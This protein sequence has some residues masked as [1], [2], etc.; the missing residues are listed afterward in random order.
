M[1]FVSRTSAWSACTLEDGGLAVGRRVELADE[2]VAVQHGEREVAPAARRLG[3]VHLEHVLEVEELDRTDAVVDEPVERREERGA[4]LERP[5][6]RLGV[7]PPLPADALDDR[8]LARV[9]DVDGLHRHRPGRRARD[10]HR[11]QPA[12]VAS[13]QGLVGR[14]RLEVGRVDALGE[15]PEPL[16][17]APR[18]HRD[19]A[20][21]HEELEHLRHVPVAGPAARRPRHLARV[22]HVAGE[23]RPGV[24]QARQH[25]LAEAGIRVEPGAEGLAGGPRPQLGQ[26]ERQIAHRPDERVELEQRPVVL[27]G[28]REP[29]RV[30]RRAEPRPGDEV[31]A[32]GDRR[33]RVELEEREAL[34]HRHELGRP[35]G[36]EQL[37]ADG[38]PAGVLP[39]ETVGCHRR[40][41]YRPA[42]HREPRGAWLRWTA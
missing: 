11:P 31:G 22:G 40:V 32:R 4:A 13:P 10:A 29:L 27:Q 12:L 41:F 6:E 14:D 24:A 18:A 28:R 35:L 30:V 39:A 3:L 23:E 36:G 21:Q 42:P 7:D 33:R 19:L 17:P 16:A 20:L 2:P 34:D 9:A 15:V 26:V 37:R 8:G 5:R 1:A 38:D 25:V